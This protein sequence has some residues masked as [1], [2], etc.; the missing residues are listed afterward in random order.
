M[1]N[2]ITGCTTIAPRSVT[3][4]T[5]FESECGHAVPVKMLAH[6][7]AAAVATTASTIDAANASAAGGTTVFAPSS[8]RAAIETLMLRAANSS[9]SVVKRTVSRF[10]SVNAAAGGAASDREATIMA[11]LWRRQA[12]ILPVG[13][14]G[15]VRGSTRAAR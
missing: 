9:P 1:T 5:S 8:E 7:K 2:A 10:A 4:A 11:F 13:S 15:S 6:I 14:V 3:T 12:T